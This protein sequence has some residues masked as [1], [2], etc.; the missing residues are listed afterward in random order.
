MHY[1]MALTP[2]AER[3]FEALPRHIQR[4]VARWLDLLAQDPHREGTR[5]LAGQEGLC[6]VHASKDYV[7]LYVVRGREVLVLVVRIAH[8]REVYRGL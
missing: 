4:R 8:R 3:E 6:R 2:E 7:I 5:K 1:R